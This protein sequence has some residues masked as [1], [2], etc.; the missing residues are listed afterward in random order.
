MPKYKNWLTHFE[1]VSSKMWASNVV[2]QVFLAYPVNKNEP[3]PDYLF[4]LIYAR[5]RTTACIRL[6]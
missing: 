6:V 3:R 4:M 5:M 2:V 1:E